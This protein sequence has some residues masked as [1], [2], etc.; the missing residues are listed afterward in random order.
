MKLK[1]HNFD[2]EKGVISFVV[3]P[4][5]MQSNSFCNVPSGV[6]VDIV[7]ITKNA[8][9][10]SE[11]AAPSTSANIDYT[12]AL[13]VIEQICKEEKVSSVSS[14]V[15][16][17]NECLNSAKVPNSASHNSSIPKCPAPVK[18]DAVMRDGGCGKIPK[19]FSRWGYF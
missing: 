4:E 11:E 13:R 6:E 17:I 14:V 8:A 15:R 16:I 12:V 18:C 7:A 19:C 5:V 1:M 10:G 2:F 9:L 3:P